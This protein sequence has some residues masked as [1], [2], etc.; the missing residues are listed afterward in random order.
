MEKSLNEIAKELGIEKC[1]FNEIFELHY[2]NVDKVKLISEIGI[3]TNVEQLRE[4]LEYAGKR[5]AVCLGFIEYFQ[6]GINKAQNDLKSDFCDSEAINMRLTVLQTHRDVYEMIGYLTLL[7]MDAL[8]TNISL[9]QAQND[10]ER[11]VLCKHAYTIIYEAKEHDLFNK[12]SAGMLKYPEDLVKRKD[13]RAFWKDVKVVLKAMMNIK[14]AKDIRNKIDSHKDDSF[15]TQISLYKK[16]DWAVSVVNLS[17]FVMLIDKIQLY[18][19]IIHRNLSVLYDH[20]YAFMKERIKQYEEILEQ[21][22][23]HQGSIS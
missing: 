5:S 17:I 2:S 13:T 12:V 8:T 9:L 22:K 4:N 10:T 1:S 6:E 23:A 20:Y 18:M 11:I 16:C 19:D 7:Q 21:L 14:E 15:V 3:C